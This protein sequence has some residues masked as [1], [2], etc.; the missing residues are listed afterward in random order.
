MSLC[1][2]LLAL[3]PPGL[4]SLCELLHVQSLLGVQR[5]LLRAGARTVTVRVAGRPPPP[6][7]PLCELLLHA[8]ALLCVG[9]G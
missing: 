4:I 5:F 9:F 2:L 3:P 7:M 1:E 6:S 8:L